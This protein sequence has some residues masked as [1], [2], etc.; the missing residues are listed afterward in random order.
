MTHASIAI[1]K[2]TKVGSQMSRANRKNAVMIPFNRLTVRGIVNIQF[3]S[4]KS[5]NAIIIHQNLLF[6]MRIFP[7]TCLYVCVCGCETIYFVFTHIFYVRIV[8][9][10]I[11]IGSY[12]LK[13]IKTPLAR[14]AISIHNCKR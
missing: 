12:K 13:I 6:A 4:I 1:N 14:V 3:V 10:L 8:N 2:Q 11:Y 7:N 9:S 5:V